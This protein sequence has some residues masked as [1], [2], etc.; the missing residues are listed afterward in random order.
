MRDLRMFAIERFEKYLI[1]YRVTESAIEV[2]R[3][4]H[5][6]QDIEG[7]LVRDESPGA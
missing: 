4:L 5:S 1:F 7:I 3:V 6:A 2:V